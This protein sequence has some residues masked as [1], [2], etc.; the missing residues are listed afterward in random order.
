MLKRAVFAVLVFGVLVGIPIEVRAAQTGSIQVVL[1]PRSSAGGAVTLYRAGAAEEGG[2]RLSEVYGG[3]LVRWG[4]LPSEALASW[5]AE[6]AAAE[7]T[8]KQ[9]DKDGSAFFP[10]LLPGLYLIKQ[11]EPISGEN[12]MRPFVVEL[13]YEDIWQITVQPQAEPAAQEPPPTGQS[14]A[15]LAAAPVMIVSGLGLLGMVVSE[16]RKIGVKQE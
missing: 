11:T 10:D 3:G 1:E 12:N 6:H 13:P 4:D 14:P 15:V 7:G 9:L 2:Y 8:V 5:L 16:R